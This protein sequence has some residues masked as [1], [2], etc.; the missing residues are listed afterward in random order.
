MSPIA[1]LFGGTLVVTANTSHT[2]HE[3]QILM[4]FLTALAVG[5]AILILSSFVL[6]RLLRLY[7][8]GR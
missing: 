2:A 3:G 5:T 1:H 6:T 8:I 7:I 4:S